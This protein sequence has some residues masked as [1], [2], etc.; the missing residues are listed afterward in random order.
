MADLWSDAH[1][2]GVSPRVSAGNA[3]FTL[4]G[5][6]GMYTVLAF[7]FCFWCIAKSSAGPNPELDTRNRRCQAALRAGVMGTIWFC[8]VAVMLAVYVVLDG[9]DLGAGIIICV[10]RTETERRTVLR[11]IGPVWDGNEVGCWRRAA[12]SILPFPRFTPPASAD[13]ICR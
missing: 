9:F 8:L 6:M 12:L 4:I 2:A 7:S 1:R 10:A 11:S 5:F 3:W 13:S